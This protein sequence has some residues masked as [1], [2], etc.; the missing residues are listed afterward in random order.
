[1]LM[2]AVTLRSIDIM[3]RLM[4][5]YRVIMTYHVMNNSNTI[6]M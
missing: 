6:Q 3:F 2:H 4:K 5:S 1:M